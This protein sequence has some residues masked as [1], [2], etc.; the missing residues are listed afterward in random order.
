MFY[1]EMANY[2][3]KAAFS[4]YSEY[5][6]QL[7]QNYYVKIPSHVLIISVICVLILFIL[8]TLF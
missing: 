2:Y 1:D 4:H 6:K 7:F 5:L 3:P 8:T